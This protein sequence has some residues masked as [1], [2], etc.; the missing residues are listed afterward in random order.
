[1]SRV[2]FVALALL[3]ACSG[4]STP[5][6]DPP[7]AP[8][9]PTACDRA[10]GYLAESATLRADGFLGR[11]LDLVDD[12][13]ESCP[14]DAASKARGELDVDLWF[15]RK[16]SPPSDDQRAQARLLYR[17][18]VILRERDGDYAKATAR[19]TK[20]YDLW[21]HPL[22]LVQ[23]ALTHS[24]AGDQVQYRAFNAR[25]LA[26]A[27][28]Q[29]GHAIPMLQT[30]HLGKVL[31][32]AFHPTRPVIASASEDMSVLL[33]STVTERPILTLTGQTDHV[34]GIAFSP[35][36]G[37]IASASRDGSVWVWDS[38]S[39][40]V[41][42]RLTAGSEHELFAL[43]YSPD[44]TR[45]ATGSSTGEIRIWDATSGETLRAIDGHISR[46]TSLAFSP[47]GL[48]LA[49]ASSD[50]T[51]LIGVASGPPVKLWNMP[52]GTLAGTLSGHAGRV[53]AIAF[54]PD[55]AQLATGGWDDMTLRIWDVATQTEVRA[56]YVDDWITDLAFSPDGAVL[57]STQP[58]KGTVTIWDVTSGEERTQL[59]GMGSHTGPIAFSPDETL[60]AM[61]ADSGIVVLDRRSGQ[62]IQTLV[63]S[64]TVISS[65]AFGPDG[66][67][68]TS[69]GRD[70]QAT[71]WSLTGD[72]VPTII[73]ALREEASTLHTSSDGSIL[74]TAA[75]AGAIRFVD[76]AR[77]D[78]AWAFPI[79]GHMPT[80][81]ALSPDGQQFVEAQE[82]LHLRDT[83]SGEE[84]QSFEGFTFPIDEIAFSRDGSLLAATD[85]D[86]SA[87][88]WSTESGAFVR[89]FTADHVLTSIAFSPDGATLAAGDV[90][91]GIT[92]WDAVSGE[93]VARLEGH[94][95][96]VAHVA[97]SPGGD[98]LASA[99]GDRTVKLWDVASAK[100]IATLSGHRD[101]VTSVAFSPDGGA[102][103]SSS[104]DRT[105]RLWDV[106]TRTPRATLFRSMSGDWVVTT[107]AGRVDGSPD[108]HSLIY[109]QVGDLQLPGYV[110]WQR[111]HTPRL[112][113][114]PLAP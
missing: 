5:H 80:S 39:G 107:P 93:V 94:T 35:D 95:E 4:P 11:A 72:A 112:L 40:Q 99:S 85:R 3:M 18:A 74:G 1:M 56:T 114:E 90:K 54:S 43:A 65:A 62:A 61:A 84:L 63:G 100:A 82:K 101:Q 102:L 10:V 111:Y 22:T 2:A 92:V 110:G 88:L 13:I 104:W 64:G 29:D 24:A 109:W 75:F 28:R 66:A 27:E 32:V 41:L 7:P 12:A 19:L 76:V 37:R 34:T 6:A 91:N 48:I 14:S 15:D 86:E 53:T 36:G 44:G 49:S 25:A 55:G 81:I 70:R 20:S 47:D 51:E 21:A 73:S 26:L 23:L 68:V 17:A 52:S 78:A 71:A 57:A 108:A 38:T 69:T 9:D 16:T 98:V 79:Y 42:H 105:V 30:G 58:A 59:K 33:W 8:S 103:V 97:F 89:W 50:L 96:W 87:Q 106:A 45:I 77:P 46:T 113:A 83:K 31:S 60:F 67:R